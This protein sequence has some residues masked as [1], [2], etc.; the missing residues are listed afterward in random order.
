METLDATHNEAMNEII[1]KLLDRPE[2]IL[3]IARMIDNEY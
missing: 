1:E 2:K 3:I